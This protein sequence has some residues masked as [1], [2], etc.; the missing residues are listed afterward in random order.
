MAYFITYQQKNPE[1][2]RE[3]SHYFEHSETEDFKNLKVINCY[4]LRIVEIF[5]SVFEGK[6]YSASSLIEFNELIKG[7]PTLR[8]DFIFC[9]Q[10]YRLDGKFSITKENLNNIIELLNIFL[11]VVIL[12]L[13]IVRCVTGYLQLQTVHGFILHILLFQLTA[14]KDR[15]SVLCQGAQDLAESQVVGMRIDIKHL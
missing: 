8:K 12:C 1:Y 4:T 10:K 9:L 2:K 5:K 11:D 15:P 14:G 7:K 13:N 3:L 6:E